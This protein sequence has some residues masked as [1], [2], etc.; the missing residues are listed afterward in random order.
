MIGSRRISDDIT[1]ASLLLI[2]TGCTGAP[3]PQS[4]ALPS[5]SSDGFVTWQSPESVLARLHCVSGGSDSEAWM[6]GCS[7]EYRT[8]HSLPLPLSITGGDC[9]GVFE[10]VD[11][12]GCVVTSDT[13][14]FSA[15]GRRSEQ[16]LLEITMIDVGWG[17]SHLL[18]LPG[19]LTVLVDCGSSRHLDDLVL[20]LDTHPGVAKRGGIDVVVLT[21][22]H[23][24]HT[25]GALGSPHLPADG[26]LERY[27]PSLLLLPDVDTD[28]AF[29]PI[30]SYARD[31]DIGVHVLRTGDTD[32]SRQDA[33]GWDSRIRVEV[34][35]SGWPGDH[36]EVNNTSLV[37][38][39]SYGDMDI[40]LT[41]DAEQEAELR[42]LSASVGSAR[43]ASEVLKL[44]HHGCED[45]SSPAFLLAV[46]PRVSLLSVDGSEVGWSLPD[47]RVL[48]L[49]EALCS[50]LFRTDVPAGKSAGSNI[51]MLSDG[52]FFE[53]RPH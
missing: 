13:L 45:A 9:S 42:M 28:P 37:L 10:G 4:P 47:D 22:A 12:R 30:T 46:S 24:D 40:L 29:G 25:G 53:V 6:Y 44:S 33:L 17:D 48:S 8:D 14:R 11:R 31:R 49:V 5:V 7:R 21:H 27:A 15:G 20:Y 1:K 52:R 50:D 36:A 32:D 51:G 2:L 23:E 39:V 43:L 3:H 35:N 19:G 18:V 16:E 26:I 34:L 41:G 38:R